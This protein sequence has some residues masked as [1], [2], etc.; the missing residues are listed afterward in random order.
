MRGL[1][2]TGCGA[3]GAGACTQRGLLVGAPGSSEAA[4]QRALRGRSSSHFVCHG[5][6]VENLGLP[7]RG[8]LRSPAPSG[9]RGHAPQWRCYPAR[10][11]LILPPAVLAGRGALGPEHIAFATRWAPSIDL[12]GSSQST[13]SGWFDSCR[14]RFLRRKASLRMIGETACFPP[15]PF[16]TQDNVDLTQE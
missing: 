7:P 12:L 16:S 5:Y 3:S 1:S 9:P 11:S 10:E 15:W 8:H 6:Q 2:A 4:G 14:W 13:T